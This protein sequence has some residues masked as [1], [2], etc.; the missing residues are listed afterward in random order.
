M[1]PLVPALGAL[2]GRFR[3]LAPVTILML[4]VPLTWSVR[5]ARDLTRTDARI[6]AHSWVEQNLPRGATLAADPSTPDFAGFRVVP[7][8]LP[9]P[10]EPTDPNRDLGRLREL[11]VRY[12]VVTGAVEDR[13]LAA[14]GD[15]PRETRFLHDLRREARVYIVRPGGELEAPGSRSTGSLAE[16][17]LGDGVPVLGHR[18]QLRRRLGKR[19]VDDRV[20]V[21]G[22]HHGR[23]GP[24]ARGRRP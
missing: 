10:G 17:R 24:R 12:V 2:A 11:G 21:Q 15:Y 1:L 8:A 18:L 6:R 20:A 7:L 14:A 3:A 5:D 13:V 9:R 16:E 22:G 19:D 4:V 23:S